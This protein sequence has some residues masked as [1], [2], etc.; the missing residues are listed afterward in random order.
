M[1]KADLRPVC[2][3]YQRDIISSE[4]RLLP[5][6]SQRK[7]KELSSIWSKQICVQRHQSSNQLDRCGNLD[8]S[9]GGS[10]N[11]QTYSIPGIYK[12]TDPGILIDIYTSGFSSYT[13]PG[14]G[15]HSICLNLWIPA[16][17]DLRSSLHLPR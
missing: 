14:P 12:A 3:A 7:T 17:F 13:I 10:Q 4:Q 9:G 8:V 11:P 16:N 6:T 2:S 1:Q 15:E 5:C